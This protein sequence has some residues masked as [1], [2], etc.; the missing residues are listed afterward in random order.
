L[1]QLSAR[2]G[3]ARARIE[4]CRFGNK[5]TGEAEEEVSANQTQRNQ[6]D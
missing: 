1:D 6:Y 3:A 4:D 5:I 2:S